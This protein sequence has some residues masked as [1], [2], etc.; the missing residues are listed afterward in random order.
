[1]NIAEVASNQKAAIILRGVD[2]GVL[3]KLLNQQKQEGQAAVQLI[4]GSGQAP[5]KGAPEP[6]KGQSV[7]YVA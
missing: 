5:K 3:G 1:M 2:V 7:D 4:E 6:G